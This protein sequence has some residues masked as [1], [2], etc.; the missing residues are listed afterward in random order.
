MAQRFT[1]FP[2]Y[3]I[4]GLLLLCVAISG[5]VGFRA[6]ASPHDF[7]LQFGNQSNLSFSSIDKV[8]EVLA[9]GE[10]VI[11]TSRNSNDLLVSFESRVPIQFP[12]WRGNADKKAMS[13]LALNILAPE[14]GL[15]D[16]LSTLR[17]NRS[18]VRET[19]VVEIIYDQ[20]WMG[21]PVLNSKVRVSLD[22]NGLIRMSGNFVDSSKLPPLESQYLPLYSDLIE[23]LKSRGVDGLL[24]LGFYH[25]SLFGETG[26]SDRTAELA[27]VVINEDT[28]GERAFIDFYTDEVLRSE[29]TSYNV[30][31]IDTWS[32]ADCFFFFIFPDEAVK[33]DSSEECGTG[34]YPNCT[35]Y[36]GDAAEVRSDVVDLTSFL[37]DTLGRISWDDGMMPICDSDNSSIDPNKCCNTEEMG[38]VNQHAMKHVANWVGTD[39][40]EGLCL[41]PNYPRGPNA[42]FTSQGC[43]TAF[44]HQYS[45]SDVIGHEF[46]H[47]IDFSEKQFVRYQSNPHQGAMSEG[48]ADIV[49]VSFQQIKFPGEGSPWGMGDG[50]SYCVSV[51]NIQYPTAEQADHASQVNPA[52]GCHD[53]SLAVSHGLYLLGRNP[54]QGAESHYGISVT[55]IGI[56]NA[57]KTYFKAMTDSIVDSQPRSLSDLRNALLSSAGSQFGYGSTEYEETRNTVNAMGYWTTNDYMPQRF[58]ERPEL[59]MYGRFGASLLQSPTVVFSEGTTPKA[60]KLRSRFFNGTNFV[61]SSPST[62]AASISGGY[63]TYVVTQGGPPYQYGGYAL[64]VVYQDANSYLRVFTK[65]YDG[66]TSDVAL[67]YDGSPARARS[68]S[69]IRI[70]S[71]NGSR[72]IFWT[73]FG[74]SLVYMSQLDGTSI[75]TRKS[76]GVQHS[77][78]YEVASSNTA[79]NLFY[80]SS[81]PATI[82]QKRYTGGSFSLVSGDDTK[83]DVPDVL[84]F[85][86][87]GYQGGVHV[88]M[89]TD[90]D[91]ILYTGCSS[92]CNTDG[93]WSTVAPIDSA[94]DTNTNM[95]S[96][97]IR[98]KNDS[99]VTLATQKATGVMSYRAK[100]GY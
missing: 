46:G 11:L 83:V 39:D 94:A 28:E 93:G 76:T 18:V 75:G 31:D 53:N 50:E 14:M 52:W 24:G 15:T 43:F 16:H 38:L 25:G 86:A 64:K 34:T 45:C 78:E 58:T 62:I 42:M 36:P 82:S 20:L 97:G 8:V 72:Y 88:V 29:P 10:E 91:G 57:F 87:V 84:E 73:P 23:I 74:Y 5:L 6:T 69:N 48:F 30:V 41:L 90:S 60:L 65:G 7:E 47:A 61:W 98:F 1:S 68:G 2:K 95:F 55:G 80:K 85:D 100:Y 32:D 22:D 27:Y 37:E 54:S 19:S 96:L 79:L 99:G 26:W 33:V 12:G 89:R 66:A 13:D 70:A 51:R 3:I 56:N 63:Q 4:T 77:Y 9:T 21:I 17:F 40:G 81:G 92:N 49:G 71:Y 59:G 67:T 44:H 35:S